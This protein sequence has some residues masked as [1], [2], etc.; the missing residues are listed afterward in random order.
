M[1]GK[2][3]IL[4]FVFSLSR[5]SANRDNFSLGQ[6]QFLTSPMLAKP[7]Q[8]SNLTLD[9][10]NYDEDLTTRGVPDSDTR[11]MQMLAAQAQH[12]GG[13]AFGD[14]DA[15]AAD[16][17][18]S[19]EEKKTMLQKALIM[20]ASNGDLENVKK[21]LSG[22]AR[23]F[24]D[25]NAPDEDGTPALVYASCFVSYAPRRTSLCRRR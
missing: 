7:L 13:E 22:K 23:P 24:V 5:P 2:V 1:A 4:G 19:E 3:C 10:P 8:F 12:L 6:S 16:E 11:L 18:L 20:S 17:K 14:V 21:I 15:I 9:D 25:I